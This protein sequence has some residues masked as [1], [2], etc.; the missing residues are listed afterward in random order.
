MA[1]SKENL[2]FKTQYVTILEWYMQSRKNGMTAA[3]LETL[4]RKSVEL[5]ESLT[6]TF[7]EK[8]FHPYVAYE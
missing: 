5:L 7:P 2:L 3:Q 8:N 6:A 4:Q 1:L